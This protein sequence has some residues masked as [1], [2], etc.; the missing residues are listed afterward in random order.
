MMKRL[1]HAI[2]EFYA[3]ARAPANI[4]T[5]DFML[6]PIAEVVAS[7][8][9]RWTTR[10]DE[11]C[12]PRPEQLDRDSVRTVKKWGQMGHDALTSSAGIDYPAL[13]QNPKPAIAS[14]VE[15]P[16]SARLPNE[17]K[18]V[19]AVD[20]ALHRRKPPGGVCG[21]AFVSRYLPP[22]GIVAF[23]CSSTLKHEKSHGRNR[24]AEFQL[25]AGWPTPPRARP[26]WLALPPPRLRSIILANRYLL[27]S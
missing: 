24:L 10:L 9:G 23:I 26:P 3:P 2:K 16:R 17:D 5:S 20:P 19:A 27:S 25:R 18:I 7:Q 4:N 14:L 21:S 6:R 12:Q 1:R 13:V 22:G 8:Q 15:F 11:R